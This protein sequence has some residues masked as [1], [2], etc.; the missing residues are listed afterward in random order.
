MHTSS[1]RLMYHQMKCLLKRN[2]K[3]WSWASKGIIFF[4]SNCM[5]L[6]CWTQWYI[7]IELRQQILRV[8]ATCNKC[9]MICNEWDQVRSSYLVQL[10]TQWNC[11]II[12]NL[13]YESYLIND[14]E[15]NSNYAILDNKYFESDTCNIIN[16]FEIQITTIGIYAIDMI[17]S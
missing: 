4:V 7:I 14:N 5:L 3:R 8:Q 15:W 2:G 17:L 10:E 11:V 13:K 16:F 1:S 12:S 9:K 6:L